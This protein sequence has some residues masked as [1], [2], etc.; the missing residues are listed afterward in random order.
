MREREGGR[1]GTFA[2]QC[3]FSITATATSLFYKPS[4]LAVVIIIIIII[5]ITTVGNIIINKVKTN[6]VD[7]MHSVYKN[8]FITFE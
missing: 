8:A 5:I 4:L 1:D 2:K 6:V 7:T 3:K